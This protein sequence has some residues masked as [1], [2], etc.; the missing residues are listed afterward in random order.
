ML[1]IGGCPHLPGMSLCGLHGL[2]Q[3]LATSSL[4]EAWPPTSVLVDP[5]DKQRSLPFC[6][7]QWICTGLLLA[8]PW[9][10]SIGVCS[11]WAP[12]GT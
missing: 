8:S 1:P 11:K 4:W 2:V 5:E 7:L 12:A 9:F 3:S 6:P 10:N